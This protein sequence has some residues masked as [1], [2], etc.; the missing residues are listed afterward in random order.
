MKCG[1]ELKDDTPHPPS[2][3]ASSPKA[4][5]KNKNIWWWVVAWTLI[6]ISVTALSM[7]MAQ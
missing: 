3:C 4:E 7:K 5:V 2:V 1:T 6:A